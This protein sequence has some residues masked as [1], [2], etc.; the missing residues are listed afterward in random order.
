MQMRSSKPQSNE[1][2]AGGYRPSRLPDPAFLKERDSHFRLSLIARLTSA[3]ETLLRARNQLGQRQGAGW[4]PQYLLD[5]IER[6]LRSLRFSRYGV[7]NL[8]TQATILFPQLARLDDLDWAVSQICSAI[9]NG[10]RRVWL[11]LDDPHQLSLGVQQLDQALARFDAHCDQRQ[12]FIAG[13]S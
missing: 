12:A 6:T 4:I 8:F 2:P 9:E 13:T 1:S 3:Q 11:T 5:R 10:V 7:R